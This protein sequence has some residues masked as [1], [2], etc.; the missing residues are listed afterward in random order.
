MQPNASLLS[1]C[2]K[3]RVFTPFSVQRCWKAPKQRRVTK[4]PAT[5][6]NP[7]TLTGWKGEEPL[8]HSGG[9][10]KPAN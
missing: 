1:M 5:H 9:V 8:C 3:S 7:R 4:Q 2:S 6:L 10:Q